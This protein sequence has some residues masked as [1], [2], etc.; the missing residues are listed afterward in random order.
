MIQNYCFQTY[1]LS[2]YPKTSEE[3]MDPNCVQYYSPG[4]L[5]LENFD[6][7]TFKLATTYI[8]FNSAG[9]EML[10]NLG[11][12]QIYLFDVNNSR[13]ISEMQVPQSVNSFNRKNNPVYKCCC[14]PVSILLHLFLFI[15]LDYIFIAN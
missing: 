10:V 8:S 1:Q 11:G 14:R 2:E 15:S 12:E 13:S 9:T 4:H 3:P 6:S 7:N 5:A